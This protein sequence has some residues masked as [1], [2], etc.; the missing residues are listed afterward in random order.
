M[1]SAGKHGVN[2]KCEQHQRSE[3]VQQKEDSTKM[4]WKSF[5]KKPLKE[6]SLI[7]VK[8]FRKLTRKTPAT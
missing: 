3:A 2:M 8:K 5:N 1:I 4:D 6:Q 7:R